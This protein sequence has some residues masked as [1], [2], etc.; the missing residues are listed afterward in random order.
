MADTPQQIPFFAESVP[1]GFPSPAMG[2]INGTLDLNQLC[3]RHPAA[4]YYVR[5]RG[6]SMTGAGIDDG[7]ILVVAR[8]LEHTHGSIVIA[9][10]AGE[11]TVKKLEQRN[12]KH[13]L[14][15]A[16]PDY[17]PVEITQEQMADIFGVVT[18]VIRQL[19]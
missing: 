6:N 4:T 11:F 12:G 10:I 13:W 3:V 2:E 15:P 16:N 14:V 9:A 17:A 19:Q 8:S 5:A 18:F 1:A 7:D